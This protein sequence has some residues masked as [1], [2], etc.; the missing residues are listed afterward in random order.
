MDLH[1]QKGLGQ[2]NFHIRGSDGK[3]YRYEI[4]SVLE[5]RHS[6]LILSQLSVYMNQRLKNINYKPKLKLETIQPIVLDE[7]FIVEKIDDNSHSINDIIDN[8]LF[9][10]GISLKQFILVYLNNFARI[11]NKEINNF[12]VLIELENFKIIASVNNT[13]SSENNVCA[14]SIHSKLNLSTN[15][16]KI[17]NTLLEQRKKHLNNY[18]SIDNLCS[19]KYTTPI[20]P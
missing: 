2:F 10:Y 1:L 7:G 4:R 3:A 16:K 13:E 14:N 6:E 19:K 11:Y 17:K 9:D 12:M 15:V 5:T 8:A 20:I 18:D